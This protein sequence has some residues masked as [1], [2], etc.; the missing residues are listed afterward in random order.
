MAVNTDLLIL[1]ITAYC[2][3]MMT[4]KQIRENMSGYSGMI[5]NV[6]KSIRRGIS[7]SQGNMN[8][9][10]SSGSRP[11]TIV[12]KLLSFLRNLQHPLSGY[13]NVVTHLLNI[14]IASFT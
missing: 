12:V 1:L 9:N 8:K 2:S 7:G 14:H 11:C 5:E 3:E 6:E 10:Y 4:L 13:N